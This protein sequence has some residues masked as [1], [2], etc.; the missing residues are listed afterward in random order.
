MLRTHRKEGRP[1]RASLVWRFA[2]VSAALAGIFGVALTSWMTNFIRSSNLAHAEDTATYSMG[3]A[4]GAIGV[5][6]DQRSPITVEQY[7][8][9]TVL[10]RAMVGTGKF[11]GATAWSP[12]ST[13]VYAV[14]PGRLG[15][16]EGSRP[17]LAEALRGRVTSA[18]VRAPQPAV[19]DVTE[20]LGLKR[21]GPLL[22]IFVPVRLNNRTVAVVVFYQRWKPIQRMIDRET[23]QM[24]LLV[25]AGLVVL[26]A[27]LLR[28]VRTASRKLRLQAAANWELA[29]HDPLTGLPNRKL[30]RERVHRA[31]SATSRSGRHCGLL[32]LDL[33]R[34]K[35]VNDTLG[36]HFGD[37][38]L[39]QV[40]PRLTGVL[41]E[42]DSVA[43]LGGDEF[44]VLLTDLDD[45]S[46]ASAVAERIAA[47]VSEPFLLGTISVDV[48]VSIGIALS[49]QHGTDFDELLQ[50]ADI[51]MYAAKNHG[52]AFEVYA[53]ETDVAS[54]ERLAMLG[55]P[56][57]GGRGVVAAGPSLPTQS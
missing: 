39:Q 17:Q 5:K 13:V 23:T 29:S 54:P 55:Q 32:L 11:V 51:A 44:V 38:L 53:P 28:L 14:E 49:P 52:S 40:G 34:F 3:V 30:L 36:H 35:E 41:R 19:P 57:K 10:L 47:M 18:V 15:R 9:V 46:K 33:D 56:R 16:H 43:R 20:R 21:G 25:T 24:Q 31:L 42:G 26:W 27:G 37:L 1:G 48:D 22:E 8:R 6:Q 2:L 12:P 45:L 4:M 7:T 50:H